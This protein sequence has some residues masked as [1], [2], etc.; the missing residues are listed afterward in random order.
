MT[1]QDLNNIQN[2]SDSP[3]IIFM[4]ILGLIFAISM[5]ITDDRR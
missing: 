4:F 2:Q 1:P 3:T 5:M